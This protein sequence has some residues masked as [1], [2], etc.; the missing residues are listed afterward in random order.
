MY[1]VL[2]IHLVSLDLLKVMTLFKPLWIS[3]QF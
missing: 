1:A 3:E 2:K